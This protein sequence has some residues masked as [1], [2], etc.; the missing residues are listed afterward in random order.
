MRPTNWLYDGLSGFITLDVERRDAVEMVSVSC[1]EEDL[2]ID[3]ND[4][5]TIYLLYLFK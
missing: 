3:S 1:K 4:R 5:S 2:S